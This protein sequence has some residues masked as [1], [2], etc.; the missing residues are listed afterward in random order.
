MTMTLNLT[1]ELERQLRAEAA[2]TG[3]PA[4]ALVLKAVEQQLLGATEV[5]S[6]AAA[7]LS[8]HEVKLLSA[9]N[10]GFPAEFWERYH[11]LRATGQDGNAGLSPSDRAELLDLSDR[12]EAAQVER[13]KLAVELAKLRGVPL[14]AL[15]RQLGISSDID[16]S[17][18]EADE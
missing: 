9:I 11:A 16:A 15:L 3:V 10:T 17:G 7:S 14:D 5:G 4:D 12:I 8:P 2:R 1:P 6:S 18:E 13:L